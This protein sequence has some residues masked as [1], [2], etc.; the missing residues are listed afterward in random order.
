MEQSMR[1]CFSVFFDP[2]TPEKHH[3]SQTPYPNTGILAYEF[4]AEH[5]SART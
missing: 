2:A 1:A 3:D 5:V 4:S